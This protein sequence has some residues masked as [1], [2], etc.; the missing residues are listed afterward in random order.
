MKLTVNMKGKKQ[1]N[2]EGNCMTDCIAK[3]PQSFIDD[4]NRELDTII[5]DTKITEE[6]VTER[7]WQEAVKE[8]ARLNG[9]QVEIEEEIVEF[10]TLKNLNGEEY[11]FKKENGEIYILADGGM[12]CQEWLETTLYTLESCGFD[13]SEAL[14]GY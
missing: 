7:H 8:A 5:A 11:E 6:E 14:A 10:F 1:Y 13:S 9:H 3:L 12:G 4:I 2:W